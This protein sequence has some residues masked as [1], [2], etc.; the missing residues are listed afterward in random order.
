MFFT[1]ITVAQKEFREYL[2]DK[3]FWYL[4]MILLVLG[5]ASAI[6]GYRQMRRVGQEHSAARALT[7]RQWLGQGEKNPHSAAHF[8]QYAFKP[9]SPLAFFDPGIDRFVGSTVWVEAHKQN[10][11]DFRPARD[12]NSL[13]RFG[14][15][16]LAFVMQTLAPLLIILLLFSSFTSEREQG[17]LK[18]LA[19]IGVRPFPL[20]L[21]KATAALAVLALL[22]SPL[23]L[24]ALAGTAS[25]AGEDRVNLWARAAGLFA[26][27]AAY[28]AGFT[29]MVLGISALC[30]TS[31]QA[32]V[33]LL[34]FWLCNGFIGPRA[35]SDLSRI[36]H[37]IPTKVEFQNALTEARKA[38]FGHDE[39]HPAF[40]AFKAEVLK[41][42]KVKRVE[43]LP[44]SFRG[45]S[46]RA[47]DQNGYRIFDE[48]YGSL[49]NG[50]DAQDRLRALIGL[51][52]PQA[53]L[54]QIS[55]GLAG[56]DTMHQNRFAAAAELYRRRI[57]DTMSAD[58][59]H[60]QKNGDNKY[61]ADD[62]LWEKIPELAYKLPAAAAAY[63]QQG[64][65]FIVL[66]VWLLAATIF[67]V[68]SVRRL[69]PV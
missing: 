11:F 29:A 65:N 51:V 16:S 44:V 14:E 54:S 35:A 23:L 32:L 28:L 12:E 30:T 56:T 18:Q 15:L 26:S 31:R 59:I 4:G 42:Y 17:T 68:F 7:Y 24:V 38:T 64:M 43:E 63:A 58:L 20:L 62:K 61:K 48:H 39:K 3:R 37:P 40:A 1:T 66:A 45:L 55:S 69:R 9:V 25:V 60:N 13:Q 67:A 22:L 53:A 2:R 34:A 41:Q 19:S 49:W 6:L 57:Q 5:I 33:V 10:E 36:L 21:G 46:L 50:Y 52:F 8:G 27:Y 47:D